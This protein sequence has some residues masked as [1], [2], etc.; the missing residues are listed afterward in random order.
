MKL[1]L[2]KNNTYGNKGDII[3]Y[4]PWDYDWQGMSEKERVA[5]GIFVFCLGHGSFEVLYERK[6]VEIVSQVEVE[7]K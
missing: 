1:K 4:E 6:D 3:M 2:L 7:E 5:F